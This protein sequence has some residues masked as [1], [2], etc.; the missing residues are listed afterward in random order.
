MGFFSLASGHGF[1]PDA[2]LAFSATWP[3]AASC[4]FGGARL[5]YL[6][7][8]DMRGTFVGSRPAKPERRRRTGRGQTVTKPLALKRLE[9]P[10]SEKQIPQVVENL[11]S[12]G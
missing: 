6:L 12:G 1:L 11:E 2:Q 10:L 3:E 7:V 8:A 9:L 5:Q 4:R